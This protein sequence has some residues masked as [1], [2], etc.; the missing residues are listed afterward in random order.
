LTTITGVTPHALVHILTHLRP[1][2]QEEIE[3]V[4]GLHFDPVAFALELCKSAVAH[5]GWIFWKEITGEPVAA[6][7]AYPMTATCAGCWAFGTKSWPLVVKDV[8]RHVR[9][10]MVPRLLKQGF[11]R[12]ECRALSTRADTRRWLE[13]FGWKAEAV[14]SG[15]GVRREDF[16]LFAWVAADE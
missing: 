8:T 10:I 16:I 9:G 6:L 4:R 2:D 11:H 3:A 15:F 1:E 12:A 14:L 13:A 5:D 7:G